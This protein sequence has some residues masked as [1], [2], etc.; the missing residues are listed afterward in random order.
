MIFLVYEM[1]G[2]Y[3]IIFI[4]MIKKNCHDFGKNEFKNI[5]LIGILLFKIVLI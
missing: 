2:Y 5:L 3:L 4:L 1:K